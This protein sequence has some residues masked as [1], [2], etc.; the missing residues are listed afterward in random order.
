VKVNDTAL[1]AEGYHG[2]N[3]GCVMVVGL[4]LWEELALKAVE[5]GPSSWLHPR[6][7]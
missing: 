4:L 3:V 7:S 1:V 5:E 2:I 6:S